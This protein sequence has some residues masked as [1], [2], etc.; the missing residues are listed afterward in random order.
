MAI[1]F[2][3]FNRRRRSWSAA[4]SVSASKAGRDFAAVTGQ[5]LDGAPVRFEG[6]G[7][8]AKCLQHET[9]HTDGIVFGDRLSA[10]SMKRLRKQ[11][12]A[13]VADFPD[14]WPT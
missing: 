4:F 7:L 1:A 9:D 13:A 10:R 12:E 6:D 5:G 3:R 14:G 11:H 8:L 2:I